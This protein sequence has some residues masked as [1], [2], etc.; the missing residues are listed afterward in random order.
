[1]ETLG[2]RTGPLPDAIRALC[3]LPVEERGRDAHAALL[4]RL[5]RFDRVCDMDVSPSLRASA[6]LE[7]HHPAIACDLLEDVEKSRPLDGR[8]ALLLVAAYRMRSDFSA[9]LAVLDAHFPAGSSGPWHDTIEA[10]RDNL[11]TMLEVYGAV[12]GAVEPRPLP[13]RR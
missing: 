5:G 10:T 8:E 4:M 7:R 11:T 12:P 13:L 3:R 6:L 1:I 9:A 2:S